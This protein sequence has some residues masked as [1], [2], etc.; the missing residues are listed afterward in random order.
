MM[1]VI[2]AQAMGLCFGVRDAL[3]LARGVDQPAR[4]TIRGE[5]V[6]NEAVQRELA[7]RGFQLQPESHRGQ[8]PRTEFVMITAHGVSNRER[9]S[10]EEAGKRLLDTTCPLVERVHD[11]AFRLSREGRRILIIGR[12]G[13]VE[14]M[15]ILGDFDQALVVSGPQ[16]ARPYGAARLGVVCQTTTPPHLAEA[17]LAAIRA[18]NPAA[19]IQFED[20]ICQPTRD[21]QQAL[22]RI[23]PEVDAVV[24]VGG[25]NS[26]NT[27]ELAR[28]CQRHNVSAHHV[29][30][31]ADLDPRWFRNCRAVGLTAGTSTLDSTIAEVHLALLNLPGANEEPHAASTAFQPTHADSAAPLLSQPGGMDGNA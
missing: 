22:L 29:Q 31:A 6:H 30:C 27:A 9:R 17:T 3:A 5:L 12:P 1:R 18:A 24:V 10:L 19:D 11:A 20:T 23:L 28:L 15:G 8:P 4:V 16:D 2:R 13:H 14:V 7:Q 26:N 25:R 21:R